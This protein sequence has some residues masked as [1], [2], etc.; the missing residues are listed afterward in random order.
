MEFGL[1]AQLLCIRA[2]PSSVTGHFLAL[3][4]EPQLDAYAYI[5]QNTSTIR[6]YASKTHTARLRFSHQTVRNSRAPFTQVSIATDA[7]V[8]DVPTIHAARVQQSAQPV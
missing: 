7:S 2:F 4:R 1:N 5:V 3:V 6:T 8:K